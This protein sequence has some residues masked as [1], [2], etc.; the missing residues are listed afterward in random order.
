MARL[1][2]R[3]EPG[4]SDHQHLWDAADTCEICGKRRADI[5]SR[6]QATLDALAEYDEGRSE[7]RLMRDLQ[8]IQGDSE[9]DS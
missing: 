4:M 2:L 7:L 3:D 9:E 6:A 5:V 8:R 1:E